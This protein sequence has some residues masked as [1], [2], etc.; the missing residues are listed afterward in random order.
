MLREDMSK[1]RQAVENNHACLLN[2]NIMIY[3]NAYESVV[4]T[5]AK[6]PVPVFL[7]IFT[8]Y[9]IKHDLI[10]GTRQMNISG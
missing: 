5:K 7:L 9:R 1:Y 6:C 4:N 8:K 10:V 2:Y 3:F